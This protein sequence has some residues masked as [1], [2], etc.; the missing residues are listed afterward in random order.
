MYFSEK[1]ISSAIEQAVAVIN[2]RCK[3]LRGFNRGY[4]DCWAFVYEYDK[5]L[6]GGVSTL[7]ISDLSYN[8]YEGFIEEIKNK[9]FDDFNDLAVNN[10]YEVITTHIPRYGDIAYEIAPDGTGTAIIADKTWWLS[11]LGNHG[12]VQYRKLRQFDRRMLVLVRPII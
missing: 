7:P 3:T 4:N 12:T 9:G 10:S 2:S 1:K 8:S 5:A 11:S 6:R